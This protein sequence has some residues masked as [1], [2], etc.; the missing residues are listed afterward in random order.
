VAHVRNE[1]LS[2]LPIVAMWATPRTV[3]T[4]FERMMI[5]RGDFTVINEPWSRFYY[6]S[7]ERLSPRFSET[8][9]V[10]SHDAIVNE[11]SD[12][13]TRAPVFVKDM[14]YHLGPYLTPEVLT[15]MTHTFLIRDPAF[16]IPSLARMWPDFT[17]DEA[18]YSAQLRAYEIASANVGPAPV[19]SDSDALLADPEAV[20]A[21]YCDAIGVPYDADALTWEP[22]M[23]PG[24]EL[25]A[26]WYQRAATSTGFAPPPT[27]RTPTQVTD[28]RVRDAIE[29][30]TPAYEQLRAARIRP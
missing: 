15:G 23:Q 24:W 11:I 28:P 29:A 1:T 21:A 5:E 22:G 18:G 10:S 6:Y 17:D 13:A 19:V 27:D 3:S 25:W 7:D 16:S 30:A 14:A 20:I 4:A 26:D 9:D 12:A 2:V 8:L